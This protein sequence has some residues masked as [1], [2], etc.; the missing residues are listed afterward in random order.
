MSSYSSRETLPMTFENTRNWLNNN[1]YSQNDNDT[2]SFVDSIEESSTGESATTQENDENYSN[3]T[4]II[5][6][7]NTI[8]NLSKLLNQLPSTF[9]DVS[10]N[11][12]SNVV[13]GNVIKIK[14]DLIL[15]VHNNNAN[16]E[17]LKSKE[18][19]SDNAAINKNIILKS[20][21]NDTA[22]S[23]L[24]IFRDCWSAIE[25]TEK[26][27]YLDEP[28]EFVIISH[29]TSNSSTDKF[30]NISIVQGIQAFH[31]GSQD[32]GDI[33]Y[34][35]LIGCDG[36][37]YEGRGWGVVGA[38]TYGYNKKSI[39]IAF[40]GNFM[41]KL[42]T[43]KALEACKRLLQIGID[44]G[45]LTKE[46]KLMGHKQCICT[47]SPGKM[48][49]AEIKTWKNFYDNDKYDIKIYVHTS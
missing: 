18:N 15:K 44:E 13:V 38:H 30:V 16:A 23:S 28:V 9:G 32:Y 41:L 7:E 24:I 45:H 48:L 17:E 35:F 29:T 22:T 12:S 49:F 34:N 3:I 39:G 27:L 47:E 14:G 36:N 31:I 4:D 8:E 33:G 20:A 1:N 42:P 25:P 5:G 11:N 37:V 46:F 10:I 26:Y 40:I 43:D 21:K 19:K 6:S 2:E